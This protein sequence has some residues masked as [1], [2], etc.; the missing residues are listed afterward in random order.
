[1]SGVSVCECVR[2][3]AR[4]RVRVRVCVCVCVCVCTSGQSLSTLV[5]ETGSLM[6]LRLTDVAHR[7]GCELQAPHISAPQ[8]WG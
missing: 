6:N 2:V 7:A 3:C 1:M 5:F 4:A 8:H